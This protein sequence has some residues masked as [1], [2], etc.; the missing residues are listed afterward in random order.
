MFQ[1][2]QQLGGIPTLVQRYPFKKVD[3]PV[4][5]TEYQYNKLLDSIAHV[6]LHSVW[7]YL[8]EHVQAY[9]AGS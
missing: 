8:D 3:I 7:S 6:N 1:S 4:Y 9:T 5:W 2:F